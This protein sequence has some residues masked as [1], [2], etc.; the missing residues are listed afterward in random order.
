MGQESFCLRAQYDNKRINSQ[1][2]KLKFL[3]IKYII[4]MGTLWKVIDIYIKNIPTTLLDDKSDY[5]DDRSLCF[6]QC[7][8]NYWLSAMK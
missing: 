3:Y 8:S 6:L 7:C 5:V 2:I 1:E 4:D